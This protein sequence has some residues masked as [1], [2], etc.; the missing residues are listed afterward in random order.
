MIALIERYAP[1]LS[2]RILGRAVF[3]PLDLERENPNLIGGDSLSGSH[4]LDQ[5]FV[6][7]PAFGWSRYKTPVAGLHLVGASTW[8]GAGF[9]RA[10]ASCSPRCWRGNEPRCRGASSGPTPLH[11]LGSAERLSLSQSPDAP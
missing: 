4:H 1:G 9:G 8:P 10:R 3:S 2:A 5:N 7:R 11:S 6:F